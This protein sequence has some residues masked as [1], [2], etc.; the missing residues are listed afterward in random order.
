MIIASCAKNEATVQQ[1]ISG[2]GAAG[3]G[4]VIC[5]PASADPVQ[6]ELLAAAVSR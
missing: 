3:V 4:E 5:F 1:Y 2:F 6:V